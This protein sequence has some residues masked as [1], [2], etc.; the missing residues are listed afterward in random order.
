MVSE[1]LQDKVPDFLDVIE[2]SSLEEITANLWPDEIRDP[3]DFLAPVAA[4]H[5]SA[6]ATQEAWL[7]ELIDHTDRYR[8]LYDRLEDDTSRATLASVLRYRLS[9]DGRDLTETHPGPQYFHGSVLPSSERAVYVDA[10]AYDGDTVLD[11]VRF[12]GDNYHSIHA[13]EPFSKSFEIAKRTCATIRGAQVVQKGLWDESTTLKVAGEEQSVTAAMDFDP[14]EAQE[15]IETIALDDYMQ[16]QPT[17]IKMDVEGAER[18]ALA[19]AEGVIKAGRPA[20]AVCVYH[21]IDD[22]GAIPNVITG[23]SGDYTFSLR[24]YRNKGSAE[25]VLYARAS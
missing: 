11:F 25:V 4:R 8:A 18:H 12:Y 9:L 7:R 19:G 17:Y 1:L 20:L 16:E 23:I 24:N 10:G 22:L 15:T 14:D 2:G 6:E 13:F 3:A 21:L 5:F